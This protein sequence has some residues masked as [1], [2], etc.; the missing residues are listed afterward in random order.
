[1]IGEMDKL[2]S[3]HLIDWSI[4]RSQLCQL[5]GDD[6]HPGDCQHCPDDAGQAVRKTEGGQV[7]G[8]EIKPG[9]QQDASKDAIYQAC[10]Q[11][12]K[13]TR[14]CGSF[15]HGSAPRGSEARQPARHVP[16][17]P[18]I[19]RTECLAQVRFLVEDDKQM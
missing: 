10:D 5:V 15:F 9:E 13:V 17:I 8:Q 7:E 19:G 6:C 2:Y 18:L 16:A 11:Y 3:I 12:G 1:L 4:R 14:A